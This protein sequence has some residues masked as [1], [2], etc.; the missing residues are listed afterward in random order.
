MA[1]Y[2][3]PLVFGV[4]AIAFAV[5]AFFAFPGLNKSKNSEGPATANAPTAPP[6]PEAAGNATTKKAPEQPARQPSD[7]SSSAGVPELQ[8]ES[9]RR[10]NLSLDSEGHVKRM[11]DG[12]L[13]LETNS[14]DLAA[15]NFLFRFSLG[16]FGVKF[17]ELSLDSSVADADGAQVIGVQQVHGLDVRGTRLN[18][19]FDA[20]GNLIYVVSDLYSGP[21]PPPP[22]PT[23][24]KMA[25]ASIARA[26]LLKYV[27][28]H[29]APAD[30]SA[31]PNQLFL[32]SSELMYQ[33]SSHSL[34]LIY[35]YTLPGKGPAGD[36]MEIILDASAGIVA[37]IR[38]LAAQ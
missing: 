28:A 2:K 37:S 3:R 8:G 21:T 29:G 30:P 13:F 12:F 10:W 23:V 31:Y 6:P 19:L 34:P 9:S 1:R 4:L 25:A 32:D 11:S 33:R 15:R 17:G 7:S 14:P 24:S 22:T 36:D 20:A 35:R 27:A 26:A 16:L 5:S 18:M 38:S